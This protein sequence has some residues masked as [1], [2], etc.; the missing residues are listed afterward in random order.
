[1]LGRS[2]DTLYEQA[3][4]THN[5]STFP[6]PTRLRQLQNLIQT[7]LDHLIQ[8]SDELLKVTGQA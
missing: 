3:P 1:M 7:A 4:T 5:L 8:R 2:M 6:H